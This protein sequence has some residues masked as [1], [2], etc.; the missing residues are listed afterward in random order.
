MN[1][2]NKF[3][4]VE[5]KIFKKNRFKLSKN[6]TIEL[7][8]NF[9]NS[10]ILIVGACGSIGR[11]V[12]EKVLK[13]NF[14]QL[15]LL[16]KNENE[17]TA[18]NREIILKLSG[19]KLLNINYICVD[20]NIHRID[21]I[22]KKYKITHYLNFAAIKHVRS[23]TEIETLKYMF[24]TNFIK[25]IPKKNYHLK[26]IFSVS[27]DKAVNPTSLLGISKYLMEN[28]LAKFKKNNPDVFVS[29][30]RFANVAFSSG[31]ILEYVQSRIINKKPFGI[32]DKIKRY[33]ITHDE[34]SDI[35]FKSMLNQNDGSIIFP[36]TK[37]K[38]KPVLILDI[39]KKILIVNKINNYKFTNIMNFKKYNEIY[40]SP[41]NIDGQKSY[42]EF[43]YKTDKVSR[44]SKDGTIDKTSLKFNSKYYLLQKKIF[45]FRSISKLKIFISKKIK[46]Y[47]NIK[48]TININHSL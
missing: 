24:K 32:P 15:I 11:K 41:S 21:T 6:E 43:F 40:L 26:T 14:N 4:S 16:D 42:E 18:L 3:S 34:A 25:C 38:L 12:T 35:C 10:S 33:F 2:F 13:F 45:K 29:T 9:N 37:V 1:Y 20:I 22:I 30:A 19:K 27:S 28:N 44:A 5:K 17:L 8:K 46:A 7:S 47:K 23:E 31:S 39:V 48:I 36:S